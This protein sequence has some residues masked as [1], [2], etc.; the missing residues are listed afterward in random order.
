MTKYHFWKIS[1]IYQ[2]LRLCQYFCGRSRVQSYAHFCA[3]YRVEGLDMCTTACSR[4]SA[5]NF[6][7]V[8]SINTQNNIV[9]KTVII[10]LTS[11]R[12]STLN[13]KA[14]FSCGLWIL[15]C[16]LVGESCEI[17]VSWNLWRYCG[18]FYKWILRGEVKS[19]PRFTLKKPVQYDQ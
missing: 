10:Y 9:L 2:N 8:R 5:S 6:I 1:R 14:R 17:I 19:M 16:S 13:D 18:K 4:N 7:K 11:D 12:T 3:S 15:A